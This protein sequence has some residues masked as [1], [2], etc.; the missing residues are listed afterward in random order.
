M[1]PDRSTCISVK[2]NVVSKRLILAGAILLLGIFA[3]LLTPATIPGSNAQRA[4]PPSVGHVSTTKLKPAG[5]SKLG[6]RVVIEG[7]A[8]GNEIRSG[9]EQDKER[10]G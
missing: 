1:L 8:I 10:G 3:L 2:E 4:K 6:G 9:P 5:T 7:D